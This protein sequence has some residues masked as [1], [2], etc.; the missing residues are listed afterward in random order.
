MPALITAL[1]ICPWSPE[2]RA[3]NAPGSIT[4]TTM[5]ISAK[6]SIRV[7]RDSPDIAACFPKSCYLRTLKSMTAR[8][9]SP[10]RGTERSQDRRP[11]PSPASPKRR[12]HAHRARWRPPTDR[13]LVRAEDKHLDTRVA[14]VIDRGVVADELR[15]A[16]T[17]LCP[18]RRCERP[19]CDQGERNEAHGSRG[20]HGCGRPSGNR[21][22]CSSG[23]SS[24]YRPRRVR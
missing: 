14:L 20:V 9:G 12:R 4:P 22:F 10:R 17:R 11:R 5:N 7:F 23:D 1:R 19:G 24:S 15:G 2:E 6:S 18:R 8:P 21:V 13:G 16:R 3:S